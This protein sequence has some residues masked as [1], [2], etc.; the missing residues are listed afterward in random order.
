[1][2]Q[3]I[4]TSLSAI[5]QLNS[6]LLLNCLD[7]LSEE[8][9]QK[10]LNDCGNSIAFLVAHMIDARH[11]I[12]S[13]L[14]CAAPN[15]IG[16]SL[17][18]VKS[19]DDCS[20]LPPLSRLVSEWNFICSH[21]DQVFRGDMKVDLGSASPHSFPISDTSILGGIAFLVQHDSF[22]LGQIAFLR[23]QCGQE[24]MLYSK[25]DPSLTGSKA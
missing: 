19:I 9:L 1:M 23:R 2:K 11:F 17:A 24:P 6:D 18:N 3:I 4:P 14:A 7:G 22:H 10:R 5:L 16:D 25:R 12:A 13:M 20:A 21:L 8:T 15:P